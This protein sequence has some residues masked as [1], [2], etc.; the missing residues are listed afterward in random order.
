M[1]LNLKDMW[2]QSMTDTSH[3]V[4]L[5]KKLFSD[6]KWDDLV[7]FCRGMIDDDPNDLVALQNLSSAYL[8]LG[9]FGDAVACSDA[10]LS[11]DSYDEY[12]LKNKIYALENLER[13]DEVMWCCDKLLE[14][15]SADVWALDSKGLAL[16]AVGR[17]DEALQCYDRS[18]RYDPNDTTA[19]V[20]KA[21]TLSFL[22]RYGD[23]IE[24]Y[25]AAQKADATLRGLAAAKSDLFQMLGME[26]DAFLAAQGLL[27]DDIGRFKEEA[28]KRKMRVFD[29]FC[30]NEFYELEA[31]ERRHQEKTRSKD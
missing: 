30:L 22:K 15:N 17:P 11:M 16:N 9:R 23:A 4:D 18:L 13:Y 1:N 21:S 14:K 24:C 5:I 26:D 19:L 12:A 27:V 3:P 31:K 25:D 7:V 6:G 10:V 29:W 28:K 20:N 2:Q 8:Q